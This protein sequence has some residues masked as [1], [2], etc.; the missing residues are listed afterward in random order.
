V[1]IERS[2]NVVA[3]DVAVDAPVTV[4]RTCSAETIG[5]PAVLLGLRLVITGAALVNSSA[6]GILQFHPKSVTMS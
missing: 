6:S 4:L 1:I 5:Y 3:L 2:S